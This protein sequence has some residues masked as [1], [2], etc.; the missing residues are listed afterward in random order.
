LR[1]QSQLRDITR[2]DVRIMVGAVA[3]GQK[4]APELVGTSPS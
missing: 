1:D 2:V 3:N 4:S